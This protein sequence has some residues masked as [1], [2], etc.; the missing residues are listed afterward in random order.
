MDCTFLINGV[1]VRDGR[2]GYVESPSWLQST[3][4]TDEGPFHCVVEMQDTS[5]TDTPTTETSA[6]KASATEAATAAPSAQDPP[7]LSST[8]LSAI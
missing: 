5:V 1:A 6:I 4:P 3:S 7:P 2:Y 8:E